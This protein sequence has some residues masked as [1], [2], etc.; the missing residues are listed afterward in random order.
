M[1]TYRCT[2]SRSGHEER[3]VSDPRARFG[4]A[5]NTIPAPIYVT[6]V[7]QLSCALH[8]V[9]WY[10]AAYDFIDLGEPST[11]AT[12]SHS[13]GYHQLQAAARHL[14]MRGALCFVF[15]LAVVALQCGCKDTSFDSRPSSGPT[16]DHGRVS[17]SQ[18]ANSDKQ[19]GFEH[20]AAMAFIIVERRLA[21]DMLSKI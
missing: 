1:Y 10:T 3:Q 20:V 12:I 2:L 15:T 6:V 14:G 18:E 13:F 21:D 16:V 9:H 4:S 17:S 5:Y 11:K 19:V 7:S 8:Q